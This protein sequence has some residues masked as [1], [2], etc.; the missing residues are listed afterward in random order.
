VPLS[1]EALFTAGTYL[2]REGEPASQLYLIID[3]RVALEQNVPGRGP[4][5]LEDLGPGDIVG[6]SWIF[7]ESRWVLDGRALAPTLALVLD[8]AALRREM[9]ADAE[10]GLALATRLIQQLYHRLER[11]RLQRLDVYRS[12]R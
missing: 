11:A 2:L 9:D 3:G 4:E 6:L 5:R 10:L 7:P 8:A 1:R 12:E